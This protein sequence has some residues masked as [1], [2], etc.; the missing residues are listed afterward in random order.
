MDKELIYIASPYAGDVEKNIEFARAA[1]RYCIE[2]G[3]TPIAVHLLY[4]QI[5]NDSDPAQRETGLALGRN[6]LERCDAVWMCGNE[7][8]PGMK[9]ELELAKELNKPVQFFSRQQIMDAPDPVYVIWA[10]GTKDGPL[11]GQSGFLWKK[12]KTM[13]FGSVAD[14]KTRIKDIQNLCLNN[15]PAARYECI[16]YPDKYASDRRM[17]LE[18]LE[19]LE[20]I[21]AFD[22]DN[23]E[24]K[25][26]AYGNTGGGCMV[27]TVQFYLPELD[28]SV[29]VNCT[30]ESASV[31]SA[32]F[33]WNEDQ[34]DS[35]ERWEN[36]CL[37]YTGLDNK[38][39]DDVEPWLPMIKA[40]LEYTIEQ[41]TSYFKSNH[42]F[43]LPVEWLPDS[44]A[45][46]AEPDYLE[47]LK[48]ENKE[49][50]IAKG[51][52]IVIDEAF[53]GQEQSGIGAMEQQ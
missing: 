41:E 11:A 48:A 25:T 20:M 5:L 46:Y 50:T 52:E 42:T 33:I 7:T 8:S 13:Y 14:A 10:D 32:D 44:I 49:I 51:G 34:S 3:H 19:N 47:W 31:T 30:D 27:G 43:S 22:P 2:W 35:F 26:Q 4:P 53:P 38:L 29:W 23:F 24:V 21:P 1:C 15:R 12:R 16:E 45:E 39:P 6:I 17:H 18:T 9:A 37:Y 28:K 36:V 40:A